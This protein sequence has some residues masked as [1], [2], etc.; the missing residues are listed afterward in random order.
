MPE[1]ALRFIKLV[2]LDN[3]ACVRI[4]QC[5]SRASLLGTSKVNKTESKY[6]SI[7]K[8]T[9]GYCLIVNGYYPNS[10]R[11]QILVMKTRYQLVSLN[12]S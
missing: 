8:R 9:A 1:R 10:S 3:L 2:R 4:N 5:L 11:F 7:L 6:A 12:Y